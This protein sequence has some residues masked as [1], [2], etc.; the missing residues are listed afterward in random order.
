[1]IVS[2]EPL[3]SLGGHARVAHVEVGVLI[4]L[5][6]EKVCRQG[7]LVDLQTVAGVVGDARG[8]GSALLTGHG[9]HGQN[10]GLVLTGKLVSVV[11][12]S[13]ETAH[14]HSS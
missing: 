6:P 12:D 9:Q 11:Q 13:E 1:M 4:D 3:T 7:P 10:L 2:V 5:E 8:I 14:D